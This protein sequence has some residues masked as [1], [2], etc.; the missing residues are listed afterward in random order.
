M[1]SEFIAKIFSLIIELVSLLLKPIDALINSMLPQVSIALDYVSSFF[2][3]VCSVVPW[4]MSWLGLNIEIVAIFV[5]YMTFKLTA[6]LAVH[7]VKLALKWYNSLK[8]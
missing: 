8:V 4:G 6:P 5:A 1:I 2:D 3:Y 7:T